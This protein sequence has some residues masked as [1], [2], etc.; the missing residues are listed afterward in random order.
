[1]KFVPYEKM[2]KKAQKEYN[3]AKRGTWGS[4][5]PVTRMSKNGKAYNR[6]VR[7]DVEYA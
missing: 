4:L 5:N 1:M 2:S 7:W 3:A 6:K